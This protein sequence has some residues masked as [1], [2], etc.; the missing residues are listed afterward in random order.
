MKLIIAI[1]IFLGGLSAQAETLSPDQLALETP[2][3]TAQ[4]RVLLLQSGQDVLGSIFVD[5]AQIVECSPRTEEENAEC[6]LEALIGEQ[7]YIVIIKVS[8][9]QVSVLSA[10][11]KGE[12]HEP[13]PIGEEELRRLPVAPRP[14]DPEIIEGIE[15]CVDRIDIC[16]PSMTGIQQAIPFAP[17]PIP[18]YSLGVQF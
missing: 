7:V 9:D 8:E 1:S 17:G 3:I 14:I 15:E 5:P 16:N 6:V 4:I 10:V 18:F 11:H 13:S 12:I 2:T